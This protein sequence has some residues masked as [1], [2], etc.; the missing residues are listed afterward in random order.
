[1]DP[2]S[3]CHVNLAKG[4][5]GGERQ[6]ELL[7][8][9]LASYTEKQF[10]VCRPNSPLAE[11]LQDVENLHILY[12]RTRLSCQLKRINADIIQAHEAKAVHWAFIH[13]KLHGIPY[14]ITR[15]VPQVIKK[16]FLS[17]LC[18]RHASCLVGISSA[19]SSYLK[20]L[21]TAT[22]TTI[23]SAL[24]HMTCNDQETNR[25]RNEYQGKI[26]IGHI[27]AYVD[28]HKG[29]RVLIEAARI[30][31]DLRHDLVFLC[32][33]AGKDENQLKEES[34]DLP[35]IKWLGFHKN[36]GDYLKAFDLFVF[37]SRNEGLGSTLLDVLDFSIPVIA[38]NVDG[39]PDII[40]DGTTGL[41]IEN[42]NGRMLSEKILQLLENPELAKN[43]SENGRKFTEE[44]IPEKMAAKYSELYHKI[45]GR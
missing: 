25:I 28:R 11:H 7:I 14:V 37:P 18:Y 22:V 32:L 26:I 19:I 43:L 23:N 21:N 4:F 24:A 12:A 38:S 39:I 34:R 5:R 41:L 44:F 17:S 6:T 40:K 35:E 8:R 29:Q 42:G 2:I 15:R 9:H 20:S 36:V 3:V 13:H 33:G 16:S 30:L 27:G 1:M 45:L 31:H 10:L